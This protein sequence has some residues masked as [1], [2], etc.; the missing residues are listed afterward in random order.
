M[1]KLIGAPAQKIVTGARSVYRLLIESRPG[2]LGN[3]AV[4]T[5]TINFVYAVPG[6]DGGLMGDGSQATCNGQNTPY[7]ALQSI[8]ETVTGTG[9]AAVTLPAVTFDYGTAVIDRSTGPSSAILGLGSRAENGESSRRPGVTYMWTDMNGDG[10][11]DLLTAATDPVDGNGYITKCRA[12][13]YPSGNTSQPMTIDLPMLPWG[14]ST[15]KGLP[16]DCTLNYQFAKL[17]NYG[18]TSNNYLNYR[19]LDTNGDGRTDLVATLETVT[20]GGLFWPELLSDYGDPLPFGLPPHPINASGQR[21]CPAPPVAPA[22]CARLQSTTCAANPSSSGN[23][24]VGAICSMNMANMSSC[25]VGNRACAMDEAW[26]P[27]STPPAW[28]DDPYTGP[29]AHNHPFQRCGLHPWFVFGNTVDTNGVTTLATNATIKWQPVGLDSEQADDSL[30][31]NNSGSRKAVMDLDGDGLFDG[32]NVG[33]VDGA[34]PA[35]WWNAFVNDGAG[36]LN[37]TNFMFRSPDGV[38][39]HQSNFILDAAAAATNEA[40]QDLVH[41]VRLVRY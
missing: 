39:I 10:R 18:L 12:T 41:H 23:C 20:A 7:R 38:D 35:W 6:Y 8:Q 28:L 29:F 40:A 32:F 13:W 21:V 31:G 37:P 19:W 26:Y 2:G 22:L 34:T 24:P 11:Q 3:A 5:R 33:T 27:A 25:I 30:T 4:H 36:T 14:G 17:G 16:Q 9:L 1:P 15:G